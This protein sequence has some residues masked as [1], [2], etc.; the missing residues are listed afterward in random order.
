[1]AIF[2]QIQTT[3]GRQKYSAR[4]ITLTHGGIL[5]IGLSPVKRGKLE[6]RVTVSREWIAQRT[7]EL[8]AH[9]YGA[10]FYFFTF[11]T[12][13]SYFG[14]ISITHGI[15]IYFR[16]RSMFILQQIYV[17]LCAL[18]VLI[19]GLASCVNLHMD[20]LCTICIIRVPYKSAS[21]VILHMTWRANAGI[22]TRVCVHTHSTT[23]VYY[24]TAVRV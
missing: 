22:D 13:A 16:V 12:V 23:R 5:T 1:M 24:R 19:P 18:P 7:R 20:I 4:P 17:P 6:M 14:S 2:G 21:C 9:T 15:T 10:N 3:N 8:M 11:R